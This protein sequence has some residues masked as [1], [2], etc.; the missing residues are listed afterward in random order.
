MKTDKRIS[1]TERLLH[2]ILAN[3]DDLIAV[4]DLQGRRLYNS[5]SY[6]ALFGGATRSRLR[7]SDSFANIHPEDREKVRKI[8]QDTVNSGT[9][10]RI[11]YRFLVSDGS[12][13]YIESQGNLV[14]DA[15]GKPDKII[16]V[17]R[18][19]TERR[20]AE[21][22][23]MEAETKFRTLVEQSLVGVYLL[24][25]ERFI[26]VNP[27]FAAIFDYS[28]AEMISSV[29]FAD[30]IGDRDKSEVLNT[31]REKLQGAGETIHMTFSGRKKHGMLNEVEFFG[32]VQEFNGMPAML[33]TLLDITERKQ[34]EE[35]RKRL[36]SAI[37]QVEESICIT[38]I[39]GTIEYVNPA[40]EQITGYSL[41]EVTGKNPRILKSNA[42]S[43]EYYAS[44]W[45]TLLR[46]EVWR[47]QL[48]NRR[49]DG[50]T[51]QGEIVISPVRS[52]D[53]NIVN[54]VAVTRDVTRER[55]LEQHIRQAQNM[56]SLRQLAGGM[57]HDFNNI[58]NV[59]L[60]TLSLLKGRVAGD[61]TL[62][63]YLSLGEAAVD[64][65]TDAAKRLSIF[66][67]IDDAQLI[68][69]QLTTVIRDVKAA[70]ADSIEKTVHVET[71]VEPDLPITEAN[72][73]QLYQCVLTLCLNARDAINEVHVRDGHIRISAEG[74]DGREVH[75][76]FP[77]AT[78]SRYVRLTV[79]D[80]GIGMTEE[81]RLH[82]FEPFITTENPEGGRGLGLAVV[83]SVVRR[84]RGFVDVSSEVGRGTSFVIYLPALHIGTREAGQSQS[85]AV[86]GGTETVL[87]VEDEEALRLLLEDVLRAKGY[88]VLTA[89]DGMEGLTSYEQHKDSIAA[90]LTD[91]GLPKLS[92]YDM[93]QKI[94]EL[95]PR[96]RVILAS[97]YLN[98]ALK[99]KLFVA[100]AKAFIAKPYQTADVLRKLR[101]VLDLP[102]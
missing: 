42:Q 96:A 51:Y 78:A 39:A 87:V 70:L 92:G 58:L 91:M 101:E 65:G 6:E 20:H 100:G 95:N 23:L 55:Q 34:A 2:L 85:G 47:G 54:Y 43:P 89:G 36:F 66:A 98:P 10:K 40:F 37:E 44:M 69:L 53:G 79:E 49:K 57:A 46:G 59:I 35:E 82:I 27:K 4:V 15:Q 8:F 19:I 73:T 72:Q 9:G 5:P 30:I 97:G 12:V 45:A 16:V 21:Q 68:P 75:T 29:P 84:H 22:V 32:S 80:N 7:G 17:G 25:D 86:P 102:D 63:K 62:E 88:Q 83:Y 56:E 24:Q 41:K 26:H 1:E 18:D 76:R 3:V 99:S 90:V 94:R 61:P 93:F 14:R 74:V 38:D 52:V 11:V 33:G 81:M 48:V 31:V 50:S 13:R 77:D 64:R 71:A 28:P 60:G 67:Q